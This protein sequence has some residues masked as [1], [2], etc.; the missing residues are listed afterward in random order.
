MLIICYG[1]VNTH[2]WVIKAPES[3]CRD[4]PHEQF[5][6]INK[7]GLWALRKPSFAVSGIQ[8]RWSPCSSGCGWTGLRTMAFESGLV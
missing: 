8:R 2:L 3:P 1:C 5:W 6:V 4:E 7:N